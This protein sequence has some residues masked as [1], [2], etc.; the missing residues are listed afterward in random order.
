MMA[1]CPIRP[2]DPGAQ[3]FQLLDVLFQF[4]DFR[5]QFVDVLLVFGS[6]T[7]QRVQA[8]VF[9]AQRRGLGLQVLMFDV[10]LVIAQRV[11]ALRSSSHG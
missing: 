2:S 1:M 4:L 7:A 9:L 3:L 5:T 8:I 6:R 11:I 10:Q